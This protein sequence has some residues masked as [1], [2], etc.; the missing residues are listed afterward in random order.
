MGS[1][2]DENY[3]FYDKETGE[4]ADF[5]T[6]VGFGFR[7]AIYPLFVLKLDYAWPYYYKFFGDMQ[8]TFSLGF[9]Y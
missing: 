9:D 2:W 7:F 1:T 3:V 6:D 8:I 4:F 5:K